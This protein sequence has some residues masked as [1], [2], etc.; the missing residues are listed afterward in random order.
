MK[1]PELSTVVALD[2]GTTNTRARLIREGKVIATTRR[3]V[4]ARD[5]VLQA[6]G[7]LGLSSAVRAAID[8][9]I[10]LG[11]GST[12][13]RI[14]AAG[15]MGSDVGLVNVP[16]VLAPAGAAE[17]AKGARLVNLPDAADTPI[18]FIPGIRTPASP[19]PA[20]W[21]EA[22]VMRGEECET[23]GAIRLLSLS[24]SALLLWPGSH[25][26][27]VAVDEVGRMTR[28]FTTMAGEARAA[29]AGHT[30]LASSLPD[31]PAEIDDM[32]FE[33][34]VAAAQHAGLLRAAFLIRVAELTGSLDPTARASFLLGAM[35]GEDVQRLASHP[36]LAGSCE[37]TLHVGGPPTLR[38]GYSRVLGR[39]ITGRVVKK[40]DDSIVEA[41]SAVGA[42]SVAT[43]WWAN[44][45]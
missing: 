40:L 2:G 26:K 3:A 37:T 11:G 36:M 44:R 1:P 29:L 21:V 25:T 32:G 4:G 22:D 42:L 19:G 43:E 8:E 13:D 16:H 28:S 41:A 12:P 14:V 45:E 24:G 6:E 9:V 31:G 35:I 38:A 18:L 5:T 39:L 20:G 30:I 10:H 27:L 15:M 17:L 7:K 34:G 33:A 23:L